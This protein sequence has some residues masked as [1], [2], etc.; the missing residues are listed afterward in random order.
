MLLDIILIVLVIAALSGFGHT[1]YRRGWYGGYNQPGVRATGG[2]GGG[3]LG[4]FLV[5]VILLL[6][7]FGGHAGP[8]YIAN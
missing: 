1:G 4:L 5:V 2:W 6:L 3:G 7:L 8:G